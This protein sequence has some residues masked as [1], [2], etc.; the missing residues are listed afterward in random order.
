MNGFSAFIFV[1]GFRA[2]LRMER[3]NNPC[4]LKIFPKH[5]HWKANSAGFLRAQSA[6]FLISTLNFKSVLKVSDSRANDVTLT[7]LDG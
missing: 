6:S 5:I 4:S 2:F 3:Y 1:N 7:E